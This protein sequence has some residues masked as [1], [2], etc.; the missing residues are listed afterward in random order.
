[1]H[2]IAGKKHPILAV[3]VGEQQ[4]LPPRR[5]GQHLVFHRNAD[6]SLERRLHLFVGVDDGMQRPVLG[7]ILHDQERRFGVGDVIMPAMARTVPDRQAV[8]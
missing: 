7:G 3:A 8:K 1:M 2:G 4:I 5:A 6:N